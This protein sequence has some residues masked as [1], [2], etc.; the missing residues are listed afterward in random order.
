[1]KRKNKMFE[2]FSK[3]V[4]KE[5]THPKNVGEIKDPDGVGRVR[6]PICGDYMVLNIKVKDEKI[7]DIKFRTFGCAAAISSSS[8]LSQMAKGKTIEKASKI[9]K[10]DVVKKLGGLPKVKV[11]RLPRHQ[12]VCPR[13]AARMPHSREQRE[14]P[15][16]KRRETSCPHDCGPAFCI[17]RLSR[18][19]QP[20]CPSQ[21]KVHSMT[22]EPSHRSWHWTDTAQTPPRRLVPFAARE[23]QS[24][25][26]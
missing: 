17:R 5:F 18:I 21:M 22:G 9:T 8:I 24:L 12:Q 3:K 20:K 1:M 14:N 13:A 10:D 11:H 26:G 2:P 4:M 7:K 16:R 15:S 6:S 25:P 19:P 23:S